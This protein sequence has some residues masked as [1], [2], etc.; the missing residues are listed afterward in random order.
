[1]VVLGLVACSD[2][3]AAGPQGVEPVFADAVEEPDTAAPVDVGVD[4]T[5]PVEWTGVCTIEGAGCDD[6]D[7]CTSNDTCKPCEGYDCDESGLVCEGGLL[8]CDDQQ[9]CTT[10]LCDCEDGTAVCAHEMVPDGS[11]CEY[12]AIDCTEGDSCEGGQCMPG[13]VL[14]MDDGN[15]CTQDVCV[16]GN[17]EHQPLNEGQCNDGNECTGDDVCYLGTCVGGTPVV[18]EVPLC[19]SSSSCEPGEGCVP[20]WSP[21]GVGCDNPDACT[22]GGV[23]TESHECEGEVA[24]DCDDLNP[25]TDDT[26]DSETGECAHSF[27]LNPCEDGDDG[28]CDDV[29]LGGVCVGGDACEVPLEEG[30]GDTCDFPIDL[31]DGGSI[32]VDLCDFH[33]DYEY[34]WCGSSGP[35][36]IFTV[37]VNYSQ[38]GIVMDTTGSWPGIMV[39]Y[40][41]WTLEK[42]EAPESYDVNGF[43]YEGGPAQVGWGGY[44]PNWTLYFAVGSMDGS[45]GPVK[46]TASTKNNG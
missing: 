5:T 30:E 18:C 21:A 16:K 36:L 27:N 32:D 24:V 13:A 3:G 29:C 19:A 10:D 11:D 39:N 41:W 25:C 38:G 4:D 23:C 44:D 40:R 45:C 35:E 31:G 6:G 37:K 33:Q 14:D 20:V 22:T 46:I 34:E 12:S 28:T 7:C 43:C 15:P 42:C 17:V 8:N 26:C 9:D 2:E 1:L